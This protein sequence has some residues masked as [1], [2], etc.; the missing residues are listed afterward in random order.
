MMT[1]FGKAAHNSAME[2]PVNPKNNPIT[3][4]IANRNIMNI[5]PHKKMIVNLDITTI[6]LDMGFATKSLFVLSVNSLPKT[7]EAMKKFMSIPML[8][9][10]LRKLSINAGQ[11]LS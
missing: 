3:R 4:L 8:A 5:M 11:F 6:A 9:A 2:K 7:Q 1:N 10:K